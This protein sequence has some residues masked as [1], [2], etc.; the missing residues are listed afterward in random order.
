ML[1]VPRVR[2]WK[3]GKVTKNILHTNIYIY[4]CID[5]HS[6]GKVDVYQM[7]VGGYQGATVPRYC[8]KKTTRSPQCMCH[9]FGM[10]GDFAH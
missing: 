4:M 10:I 7:N 8:W 6:A 3:G 5:L 9:A 2:G 1:E